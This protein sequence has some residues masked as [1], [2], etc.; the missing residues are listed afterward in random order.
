MKID[1]HV[2]CAPQRYATKNGDPRRPETHY[3]ADTAEILQHMAALQIDHA[4]LMS[5]CEE[6]GVMPYL[7]MPNRNETCRMLAQQH[8]GQFSWMC[9]LDPVH[10]ETVEERLRIYKAQ[11]AVGIGE[12]MINEWLDSP[13]L[14]AMF[15]AAERQKMPVLAHMNVCVGKGGYGVADRW[16]LPLLEQV[17][18]EHPNLPIIGHS[19]V[20]WMEISGDCP[21]EDSKRSGFGFGPVVP[22]GRVVSLMEQYPNLYADLSAFSGARAILRDEAFGIR[23]CERFQDRLLF[24]TDMFNR[25][26]DFGVDRYLIGLAESGKLSQDAVDKIL[27][28]NAQQLFGI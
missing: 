20:F 22:G 13:F 17:L 8:P 18:R 7:N 27:F 16:G 10:P 15:A 14:T 19:Q 21:K 12:V 25:Y 9:A 11:G 24:G 3:Q 5:S 23:F 6:V 4:I 28:R 1:I 26:A 2:H